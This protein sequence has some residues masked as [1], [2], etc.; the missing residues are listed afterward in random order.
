MRALFQSILELEVLPHLCLVT[1]CEALA[2]EKK[3][4][5]ANGG[6]V[7]RRR[8]GEE[9][10]RSETGAIHA[11]DKKNPADVDNRVQHV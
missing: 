6:K 3:A 1:A 10:N 9:S 2:C 11:E 4:Q 8:I 5:A 7:T